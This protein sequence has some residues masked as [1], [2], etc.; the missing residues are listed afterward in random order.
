MNLPRSLQIR[1]A[2]TIGLGIT[3]LWLAAAF[4]TTNRLTHEMD[5]VFDAGLKSSAERLMPLAVRDVKRRA[6]QEREKNNKASNGIGKEKIDDYEDDDDNEGIQRRGTAIVSD[7]VAY[8]VR[9]K[10]GKTIILSKRTAPSVFPDQIQ[11][12]FTQTST[13]QIYVEIEP[14][15]DI[16][17]AVAEP[18]D[19]RKEM[20]SKVMVSLITPLL[21]VIPLSLLAILLAVRHLFRPVRI[22]RATL[23]SRNAQDLSDLPDMNLPAELDPVTIGINSLFARL[24]KAFE[25]E[26]SFAANAAHELRTPVAGA[27]AQAQ[28]LMSET[29]DAKAAERASDIEATLKRLTR[30]SEK[31]LQFARAEGGRAVLDAPSDLAPVLKVIVRDFEHAGASPICLSMPEEPILSHLEP[32]LFGILVRNLIEN[33][34]RHGKADTP[35]YVSLDQHC[36][37]IVA[38]EGTSLPAEKIEKLMQRFEKGEANGNGTGLG[39]AIVKTIID[40]SGATLKIV[41]PLNAKA[42]GVEVSIQLP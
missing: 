23:E 38:N 42:D 22:F 30:T 4:Y 40:R 2:V 31:L 5:E 26:R 15:L 27:I 17:L 37:L 19:D 8:T 1:L 32:D 7:S 21:A 3:V 33:A 16:S 13:H 28:R 29:K 25:A 35:I 18:L 6:N 12:G 36:H 10:T 34:L 24:H 11:P 14:N 39:L 20:A 9:D 41:S